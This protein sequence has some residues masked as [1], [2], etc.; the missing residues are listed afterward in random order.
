MRCIALNE[1]SLK[2]LVVAITSIDFFKVITSHICSL[3]AVVSFC[4]YFIMSKLLL[5]FSGTLVLKISE[6]VCRSDYYIV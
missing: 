5:I 4:K 1:H 3:S 6:C 2:L